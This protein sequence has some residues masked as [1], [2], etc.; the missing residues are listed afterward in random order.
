ML[1]L[2]GN[3]TGVTA[4]PKNL[5][6][7]EV[8]AMLGLTTSQQPW[9]DKVEDKD[10]STPPGSPSVG[11]RYIVGPSGTAAWSG[12]DDNIAEW[13]GSSWDF[14][15]PTEGFAL[16]IKDENEY[17]TFNG[18]SWVTLSSEVGSLQWDGGA[19]N[20]VPATG[21]TS[22]GL[23]SLAVQNTINNDDWSG[24]D[25]SILNGGTGASDAGTART[26][27]GLI[28]GT[29]VQA[30]SSN[31]DDLAALSTADSNFIVG[32]ALGWVVES[33]ATARTSL[34]LGSLAIQNTINNADWSGTDLA[35]LNGGTGASDAATA[36]TN[37]GLVIGTDVQA[38]DAD[39]D[40]LAG[41]SSADSNFIVGSVGGWIV[42]SGAT[43]RTSLGLGSL[44]VQNTINN[45]DW[46]G[47]DLAVVNGGTGA[48]DASTARTN[49]G[50]EAFPTTTKGDLVVHNGTL[51]VRLPVGPDGQSLSAN[52][53]TAEGVEWISSS[54]LQ[55]D[56]GATNLVPATGRTS[57]GLVIG[58]DVQTFDSDLTDIAALS[59]ADSN[60]IVGSATGWVAESGNTA[61]TSLGLGTGDS[62]TLTGLTLSGLTTDRVVFTGTGGI[63]S[64]SANLTYDD[65]IGLGVGGSPVT[66][67]KLS[68]FGDSRFSGDFAELQDP[69][70]G[71]VLGLGF[72]LRFGIT[73]VGAYDESLFF[74][75]R[76]VSSTAEELAIIPVQKLTIASDWVNIVSPI[77]A[78][79]SLRDNVQFTIAGNSNSGNGF[80]V[81]DASFEYIGVFQN[82]K[83]NVNSDVLA[84]RLNNL[85]TPA[86]TNHWISFFL[87][88]TGTPYAHITPDATG[89]LRLI[90]AGWIAPSYELPEGSDFIPANYSSFT[91]TAIDIPANGTTLCQY[92]G[93]QDANFHGRTA[94]KAGEIFALSIRTE[95]ATTAGTAELQVLINGVAQTGAGETI[96]INTTDTISAF[97]VLSSPISFSAGDHIQMQFVTSGFSIATTDPTGIAYLTS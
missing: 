50:V 74:I 51:N 12:Q 64:D 33:G 23:G 89:D 91:G 86:T 10:L 59:S 35:V 37:L 68:I 28:I 82:D 41:L 65:A 43:V 71:G 60:F 19:T 8:N 84:L 87:T 29:D 7:P 66:G 81:L 3:D 36:R 16:W 85:T 15:I 80:N 47:T 1:T 78:G 79:V 69:V 63:L 38:W 11:D 55:W 21:R 27:L 83:D 31:L 44:A 2:K 5:T 39:L 70:G 95:L 76:I 30:F 45:D 75:P 20:L 34:G 26:N 88:S 61:R 17:Y 93:F 67:F 54:S 24:T 6:V 77:D 56:G 32:S 46:S 57:L 22:L 13:N 72:N 42:E 94:F 62:P 73:A 40:T 49:L 52:S 90:D 92:Q 58:T 4:D 25:L 9:Q 96:E 14:T 97:A 18:A 53:A 48:S